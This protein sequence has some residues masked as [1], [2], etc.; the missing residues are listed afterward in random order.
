MKN[1]ILTTLFICM[2]ISSN[3]QESSRVDNHQEFL[4]FLKYTS[5]NE[6]VNAEIEKEFSQRSW[7]YWSKHK[8]DYNSNPEKYDKTILLFHQ[9]QLKFKRNN[10]I[11]VDRYESTIENYGDFDNR[12]T[13]AKNPVLFVGSSSIVHWETSISFPEFPIIN[14]GFGGASIHE[15][16]HYYDDIIKKHTPA[17]LVIYS[18]I[19]IE[20]G[21]SPKVAVDAY[22]ELINKVKKDFPKTQILLLSMKPTLID[23][24]LG[25]DVRKNKIISNEQLLEYCQDEKNIHFVDVSTPMSKPDGSLRSDIFLSDG[26]HMN[27][28]GYTIWNPIIKEKITSVRKK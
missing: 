7:A 27:T 19:D 21:K 16:I 1:T 28:L 3:A 24:F 4:D 2:S 13:F 5:E 14:R 8:L 23:D 11:K 22:K 17:I 9:N 6:T 12:N 26:M 18:D 20:I 15:I 25:K 10:S